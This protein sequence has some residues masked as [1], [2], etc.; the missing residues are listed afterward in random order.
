LPLL[1]NVFRFFKIT[2][3]QADFSESNWCR[4]AKFSRSNKFS[5]QRLWW[6]MEWD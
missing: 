5:R 6:K 4:S 1:V 2:W 3:L